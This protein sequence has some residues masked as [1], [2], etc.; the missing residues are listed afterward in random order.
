MRRSRSLDNLLLM[1]AA[2]L[3][4]AAAPHPETAAPPSLTLSAGVD[5]TKVMVGEQLTLTITLSGDLSGVQMQ[6]QQ[7]PEAFAV[8]AQSRAQNVRMIGAKTERSLSLVYLL[9]ARQAGK[10]QLGPFHVNQGS[11]EYAADP[12]EVEVIRSPLP[13]PSKAPVQR[14]MI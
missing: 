10:F 6:E 11:T 3:C 8:V 1:A 4:L 5:K 7:V 12:L 14:L 13:P 2:G 9:V